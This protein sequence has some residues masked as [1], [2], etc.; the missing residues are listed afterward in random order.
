MTDPR[1]A[2]PNVVDGLVFV[3]AASEEQLFDIWKAVLTCG[4]Q[5]HDSLAGR[6]D[7]PCA[8]AGQ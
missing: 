7:Y 3:D 2:C 4:F 8:Q 5:G 1:T 6:N